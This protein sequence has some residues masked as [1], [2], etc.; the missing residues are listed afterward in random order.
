MR[1]PRSIPIR[2]AAVLVLASLPAGAEVPPHQPG[3]VC[4]TIMKSFWCW[5]PVVG[6]PGMQCACPVQNGW[7][8]GR[9]G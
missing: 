7:V 8:E 4:I 6:P 1:F 5:A 3:T 9:L 2:L